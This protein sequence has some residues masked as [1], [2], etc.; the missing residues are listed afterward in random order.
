MN[1]FK[2]RLCGNSNLKSHL[3]LK[4]FP[5]AAQ[6]FLDSIDDIDHD[7]PI[8]LDVSECLSC[9]LIQ[10]EN[11]PVG[12]YKDVITAASLS[13]KSKNK[14]SEEWMPIIKKYSLANSNAVEVGS[15]RGD[16]LE[17]LTSLGFNATGIEN[18]FESCEISTRNGNKTIP[19]YLDEVV[20]KT[21]QT[22]SLVVCNNFLEHQPRTSS[23]INGLKAL[24]KKD[25]ILYIS[26]P[27][28]EYLMK[29][30]C[31][32]EFVADHLV[33]FTNKTL[34]LALELNG[35]EVL[36]QYEK[37]NGNDLVIIAKK[38]SLVSLDK[39]QEVVDDILISLKKL[40][41]SAQDKGKTVSVWSAGHR[42][43]ALMAMA[44]FDYIENVVDSANFKQGKLTPILHK[45]IISPDEFTSKPSDI[46][47][48]MLPGTY[49]NQVKE[50]LEK[51]NVQ[52]EVYLFNDE[53]LKI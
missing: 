4:N 3:K 15:C 39:C 33:Y 41:N 38:R 8:Q 22:F 51:N 17:V 21:K 1:I 19:G 43:L 45:K 29:K 14:L 35:L 2:C 5:K 31:L 27:N 23:F 18:S 7:T 44:E 32:Y 16:F 48:L 34:K 46:I 40:V 30:S 12:Y 53:P 52:S 24:L 26:V 11:D 28:L 13:E 42:A 20:K 49:S 6:F 10:L 47:I 9:G 50:F 36:E 25:G 37:N